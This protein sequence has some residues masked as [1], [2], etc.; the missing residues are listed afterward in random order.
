MTARHGHCR[1]E[2][3]LDNAK[4][5]FVVRTADQIYGEGD[6]SGRIYD[7][8]PVQDTPANRLLGWQRICLLVSFFGPSNLYDPRASFDA[9]AG[10]PFVFPV[11]RL[12][13]AQPPPDLRTV[14]AL[15]CMCTALQRGARVTPQPAV[16]LSTRRQHAPPTA[17]APSGCRCA[18]VSS[19]VYSRCSGAVRAWLDDMI[20]D[21]DF[22][23]L[24]PSHFDAPVPCTGRELIAAFQRSSDVYSAAT[25]GSGRTMPEVEREGAAGPGRNDENGGRGSGGGGFLRRLLE[26]RKAGSKPGEDVLDPADLKALENI[27]WFLETLRAVDRRPGSR[28]RKASSE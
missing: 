20:A 28:T 7:G 25:G 22:R 16:L 27:N 12:P 21:W 2:A 5:G 26:L 9:Y 1:A 24:V 6:M 3:L 18:Q 23:Q 17:C 10:R 11:V 8:R 13:G 14:Q 15:A 4:N 19:L